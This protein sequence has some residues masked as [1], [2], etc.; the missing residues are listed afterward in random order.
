MHAVNFVYFAVFNLQ[1]AWISF[2]IFNVIFY[3]SLLLLLIM[4]FCFYIDKHKTKNKQKIKNHQQKIMKYFEA[5]DK[6][7]VKDNKALP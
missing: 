3:I 5:F 7:Q 2:I 4:V 6:N 1:L